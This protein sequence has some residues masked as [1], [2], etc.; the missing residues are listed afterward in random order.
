MN[1]KFWGAT[2]LLKKVR[3]EWT[4]LNSDEQLQ[5]LKHTVQLAMNETLSPNEVRQQIVALVA[6]TGDS[7]G[8][9]FS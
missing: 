5:F 6:A 7:F 4:Q 1:I 2:L 8:H 9:T 3:D